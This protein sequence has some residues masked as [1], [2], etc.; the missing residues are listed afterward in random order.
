[1][2]KVKDGEL[3]N[4]L[5]FSGTFFTLPYITLGLLFANARPISL[6]MESIN[7]DCWELDP[8]VCFFL[9]FF[10]LPFLLICIT[11]TVSSNDCNRF[12]Y[13]AFYCNLLLAS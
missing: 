3:E 1:M 11:L 5:D 7:L 13:V 4:V 6:L 10:L 12:C 8:N 9:P 2:V